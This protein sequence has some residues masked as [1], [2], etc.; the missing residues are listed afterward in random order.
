[1]KP[2]LKTTLPCSVFGHNYVLSKTNSNNTLELK[3]SHCNTVTTTDA[4]GNFEDVSITNKDIR[5]TLRQLFHLNLQ[6]AKLNF[7]NQ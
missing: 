1:M 5:T 2:T 7:L 6:A 4:S 3:C